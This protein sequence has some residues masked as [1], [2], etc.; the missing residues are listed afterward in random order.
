M[1]FD[2]A[3]LSRQLGE[4]PAVR[5][6]ITGS[7]GSTP[8]EAGTSMLVFQ[9]HIIGTIG[10][11]ALE[12]EAISI[13][14]TVL[15]TGT[16]RSQTFPLGPNLGQCCGGSVTLVWERMTNADL[17]G[18]GT[19]L[20][21]I[22]GP[23]VAPE[24]AIRR[25]ALLQAGALP[26][27]IDGWLTEAEC[28]SKRP[29]WIWG[30]GHVGR[31]LVQVLAPL[32]EFQI[33][34]VDTNASRFPTDVAPDVETLTATD[35]ARLV[36]FAPKDAE[37][38]VLTYSHALDLA[39]CNALLEHDFARAGVIGSA[40]KWTRFSKRL[41]EMGHSRAKISRIDCPIGNP[42]LGKHPQAIA[43]GVATQMLMRSSSLSRLKGETG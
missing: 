16:A 4:G 31:A 33:T 26:L 23:A 13:A 25:A 37:H 42:S 6:L 19:Y 36:S 5:I 32:G 18:S 41:S 38:I 29:L 34:W 20:R 11:G 2:R 17:E 39:L 3:T 15:E 9:D 7:A 10:G 21:R 22:D 43:L 12:Q 1:S 40:T 35:L 24:L 28:P 14:K 27:L 8:R 30:A